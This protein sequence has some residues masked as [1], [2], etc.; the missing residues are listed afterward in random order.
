M[1]NFSM[2]TESTASRNETFDADSHDQETKKSYYHAFDDDS[3]DKMKKY[4]KVEEDHDEFLR[5]LKHRKVPTTT[6][7]DV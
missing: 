7:N 5:Y 1:F 3:V 4:F 2:T 6:P